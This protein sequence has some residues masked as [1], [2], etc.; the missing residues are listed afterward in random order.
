MKKYVYFVTVQVTISEQKFASISLKIKIFLFSIKW[1]TKA[2]KI[3]IL[4]TLGTFDILNGLVWHNLSLN[5]FRTMKL[6]SRCFENYM[7]ENV[8]LNMKNDDYKTFK[9]Q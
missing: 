4:V 9:C 5:I 1:N 2:L 3:G 7:V 6:T 8:I